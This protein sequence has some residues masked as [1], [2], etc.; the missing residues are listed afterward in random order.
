[1]LLQGLN[2]SNQISDKQVGTRLSFSPERYFLKIFPRC[3][4]SMEETARK[5]E[6]CAK[7]RC[8]D[9]IADLRDTVECKNVLHG[10]YLFIIKNIY[11][12]E[13]LKF[14]LALICTMA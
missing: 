11:F 3:L 14:P 9:H 13:L 12:M 7:A 2:A 10:L 6:G 8:R 4:G 5:T 1:M